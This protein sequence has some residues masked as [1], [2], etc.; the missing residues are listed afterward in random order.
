MLTAKELVKDAVGLVSLPDIYIRLR[1]L[2]D[3]PDYGLAE[4]GVLIGQDPGL[5]ARLL[6]LVNSAYFGV[7]A[8]I[9]TVSRAVN[10]L[11]TQQVHDLVLATSVAETFSDM[12]TGVMHMRTYWEGSIR[13]GVMARLLAIHCNML[14]SE[15]LFVAGLLRDIGHL[16][17]YQKYPGP[18]QK[19]LIRA[20]QAQELV[21]RVERELFGFDY[22]QV[23]GELAGLWN[24]PPALESSIRYHTVP[25]RADEFRLEASIIHLASVV[26]ETHRWTGNGEKWVECAD[27]IALQLTDLSVETVDHLLVEAG[28]Q[29]ASTVDLILPN[30][31]EIS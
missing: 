13:C 22:A 9:E 8:R 16:L 14:D 3:R 24:L 10:M 28:D 30:L 21:F 19:A 15:R 18:S 4:V 7:A 17:M 20:T 1:S 31:R 6:H 26:T 29:V 5:T 25:A 27:P 2:L 23:G 12:S 11:G